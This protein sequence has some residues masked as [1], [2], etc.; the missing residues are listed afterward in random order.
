MADMVRKHF[1]IPREIAE[2]FE[3]IAGQ[4]RQSEALAEILEQWLRNQA[5]LKAI[6][7]WAGFVAAE[8]HP[9]WAT[10]DDVNEWVRS[11]RASE[12]ERL[13]AAV[14]REEKAGR[15]RE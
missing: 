2:E 6:H 7:R 10:P 13:P 12:W 4:R 1:T 14:L 5:L 11:T 9:E 15:E 8:D 3:R